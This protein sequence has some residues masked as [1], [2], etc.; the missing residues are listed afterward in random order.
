MSRKALTYDQVLHEV[1]R[2]CRAQFG[3]E[4][5]AAY[6]D[7]L[8]SG[9]LNRSREVV[10][11]SFNLAVRA[12]AR[13]T[14]AIVRDELARHEERVTDDVIRRAAIERTQSGDPLIWTNNGANYSMEYLDAI[15]VACRFNEEKI[16]Q[17]WRHTIT[18]EENEQIYDTMMSEHAGNLDEILQ[19]L[20]FIFGNAL[21]E[22]ATADEVRAIVKRGGRE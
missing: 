6:M 14:V 3:E 21:I 18:D 5:A 22:N 11:T 8:T 9:S 13:E 2:A 17:T 4:R 20:V 12:D 10:R 16:A 19:Q 15:A 7:V 1:A